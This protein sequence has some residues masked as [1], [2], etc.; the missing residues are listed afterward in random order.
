MARWQRTV[1]V[2]LTATLMVTPMVWRFL[3]RIFV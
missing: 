1:M 2:T 3:S